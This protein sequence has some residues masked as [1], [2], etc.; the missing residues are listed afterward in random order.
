MPVTGPLPFENWAVAVHDNNPF[1]ERILSVIKDGLLFNVTDEA[2][3]DTPTRVAN[4][5]SCDAA[6]AEMRRNV[7]EELAA[8]RY[9]KL[10]NGL[11]PDGRKPIKIHARGAVPKKYSDKLRIITDMS[12]PAGLSL[13]DATTPRPFSAEGV[14]TAVDL[15]SPGC[16]LAKVDIS[17]AFR[18]IAIALAMWPFHCFEYDGDIYLDKFMTFGHNQSPEV[19][20][21]FAAVVNDLMH[22]L[23]L[24]AIVRF[25]DDFLVIGRDREQCQEAFDAL[26]AVLNF[27]GFEV[28]EHKC[29]RPCQRLVFLGVIFDTVKWTWAV[30]EH[31]V[32]ALLQQVDDTLRRKRTSLKTWQSMCGRML[33]IAKVLRAGRTFSRRMLDNLPKK[34]VQNS[35]HYQLRLTAESRL[36]L[37]WWRRH[38]RAWNGKERIPKCHPDAPAPRTSYYVAG[39]ASSTIGGGAVFGADCIFWRWSGAEKV[40]LNHINLMELEVLARSLRVWG[41][42][43]RDSIVVFGSDSSFTV[44][45]TNSGVSHNTKAMAILRELWHL[46]VIFN[47]ELRAKWLPGVTNTLPD[48]ASRA[49][50][51]EFTPLFLATLT[52]DAVARVTLPPSAPVDATPAPAA[53]HA[54]SYRSADD[55]SSTCQDDPV[56]EDSSVDPPTVPS[57][58]RTFRLRDVSHF[59]GE[60]CSVYLIPGS[61]LGTGHAGDVRL[62]G[63]STAASA[64]PPGPF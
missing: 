23:G 19:F 43:W 5:S 8:G 39:D 49:R 51:E 27:L 9:L 4:Y 26:L 34:R 17:S 55:S 12:A 40:A 30:E 50:W 62:S 56:G 41:P 37:L 11:L 53:P 24:D 38:L 52:P 47:I 22:D 45:V 58:L 33:S 20:D 28:Q 16:F 35:S 18:H 7:E 46:C 42:V 57:L 54:G 31:K 60:A 61:R 10:E 48:L 25:V 63:P 15:L 64:R 44:A 1:R 3:L 32:D 13:N 29:E 21:M 2:V 36:D 59:G 14:D 6:P